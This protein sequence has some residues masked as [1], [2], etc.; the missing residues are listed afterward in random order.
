VNYRSTVALGLVVSFLLHGTALGALFT[1]DRAKPK[2]K[3]KKPHVRVSL[4]RPNPPPPPP[5]PEPPQKPPP[6]V[7]EKKPEPK[8]VVK[9]KPK[10]KKKVL[11]AKK[12]KKLTPKKPE[13]P[14]IETPKP[15]PPAAPAPRKFA[16][17]LQATISTGG[18]AVP[19]TEGGSSLLANASNP[20]KGN[21]FPR[22]NTTEE[23]VVPADVTEVTKMPRILRKPTPA[24][25][26]KSYPEDARRLGLEGD[27]RLELLVSEKGRVI[28]TR[29][30]KRA[31][32]GFDRAARKLV[33]LFRFR[34]AMQGKKPVAVW[35]PW[36]Y[37]FRLDL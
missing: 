15:P 25:L 23:E 29:I 5:A 17:N 27:V 20:S 35:I 13:P 26:Q 31:G 18:I 16:V 6:K 19:T 37:K 36:T 24:E 14:P 12:V 2:E 7:V 11:R 3:L 32:N 22:D 34:P 1:K 33:K 4:R 10:P 30:L 28:E 9:P 21:E 8:P